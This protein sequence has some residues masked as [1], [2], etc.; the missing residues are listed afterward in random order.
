MDLVHGSGP[1]D[2]LQSDTPTFSDEKHLARIISILG[3]PPVDMLVQIKDGFDI[4]MLK[5][6]F[7][8]SD[9]GE[10]FTNLGTGKFKYPESIPESGGLDNILSDVEVCDNK[11][12]FLNLISRMLR[13][14]LDDRDTVE[15]L[16]S[17]PWFQ[18]K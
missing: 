15:G 7:D 12:G 5:V 14:R 11:Q 18:E 6:S 16:L 2:R 3:P 17:D 8:A 13:W 10:S 4:L 9:I 1:F